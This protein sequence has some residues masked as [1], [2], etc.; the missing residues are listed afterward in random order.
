MKVSMQ[1]QEPVRA[2]MFNKM[3]ID[4]LLDSKIGD[5]PTSGTQN[6]DELINA[7]TVDP[8]T[9]TRL[10]LKTKQTSVPMNEMQGNDGEELVL[11]ERRRALFE[12][13]VPKRKRG[14]SPESLLPPPDF[15][16]T[17]YPRGWVVGKKRKLVNVDVVESMRRIAVHEMN[18]KDQEIDGLN[19]QLEEDSRTME[20]LQLQLQQER[21]KRLQAERENS[22]LQEQVTMLMNMLNELE[23]AAEAESMDDAQVINT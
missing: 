13:L 21:N 20:H 15:E 7:S 9:P 1:G 23:E 22:V 16:A 10:R 17:S 19:E 11:S 3:E 6:D 12:P 8:R 14:R 18:R 4:V 5:F 2:E